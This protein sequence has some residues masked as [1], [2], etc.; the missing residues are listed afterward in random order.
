MTGRRCAAGI[1]A[2]VFDFD[3]TL[4]LS[5]SIKRD[6]FFDVVAD[7]P[8]G[9][10]RMAALLAAPDAGDRDRIFARFCGQEAPAAALVDR[11]STLCEQRILAAP[12]RPGAAEL[13]AWLQRCGK[14]CFICSATPEQPLRRI[15][16]RRYPESP[17]DAVFGAPRSKQEGLRLVLERLGL[18]AP[19]L[20]HVGDGADDARA[21]QTVGCAFAAVAGQGLLAESVTGAAEADLRAVLGWLAGTDRTGPAA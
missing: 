8:G 15:V 4:V 13:L 19:A 20:L 5:N 18:A 1:A 2:V 11:Y 17:F 9:A 21:A 16:S 6:T 12:A 3:G 7:I 10:E 14:P